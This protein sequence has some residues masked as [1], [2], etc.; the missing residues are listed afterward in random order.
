VSLAWTGTAWWQSGY[1]GLD[2]SRS[3]PIDDSM[4]CRRRRGRPA[5]HLSDHLP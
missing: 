4:R 1:R 2:D 3:G 5:F